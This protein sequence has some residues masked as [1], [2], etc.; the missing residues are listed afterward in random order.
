MWMTNCWAVGLKKAKQEWE[1]K[2][3]C[4]RVMEGLRMDTA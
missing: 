2:G 1:E 3:L 4:G